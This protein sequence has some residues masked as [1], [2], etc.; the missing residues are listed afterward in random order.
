MEDLPPFFRDTHLNLHLRTFYLNR[1]RT[2][3]TAAEAL[4]TG[5][6]LDYKSGWFLDTFALGAVGYLSEPL[7]A[8]SD[9]D[10]TG[11]FEIGQEG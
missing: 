5:G 2:D 4:A 7:Y 11:L 10:R 1:T 6:W 9:R 3:G 8:P